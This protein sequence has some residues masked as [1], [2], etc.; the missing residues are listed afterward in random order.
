[1]RPNVRF[2]R[3]T[4]L[5]LLIV[6][7]IMG[8]LAGLLLPALGKARGK[9]RQIFCLNNLKQ[10]GTSFQGY[11]DD[12]KD[13]YPPVHGGVYGS[14]ERTPPN[15]QEWNKYLYDYGLETK[16]MRCPEDPCVRPDF[17]GGL[18]AWD[19]RQ[20]YMYNGMFAFNNVQRALKSLSS[21]IILSARGD[22]TAG[23]E[24]APID[25]Q[26]YPAFKAVS[27][28]EG[29]VCKDRHNKASNYLF[30]DGHA[31]SLPFE[32]SVGDRTEARNAHFVKDYLAA[33]LP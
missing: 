19:E 4:L 7:A 13:F 14:P 10:C 8:I 9:A 21:Q 17:V 25:H 31:E 30:T 29:R 26:G 18:K 32:S 27:V 11:V 3:F 20:S 22:S 1:M 15:C 12:W 33:Y 6:V 28:W 23:G 16:H 2:F 24:S 5:E